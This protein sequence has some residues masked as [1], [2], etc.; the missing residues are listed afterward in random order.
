MLLFL[1][2]LFLSVYMYMYVYQYKYIH[3]FWT[4]APLSLSTRCLFSK[5]KKK[6]LTTVQ[7]KF[8]YMLI[9]FKKIF[10]FFVWQR[11]STSRRSGRQREREKLAP[12]W[13]ESSMWGLIPGLTEPPRCPL[14]H[15]YLICILI[16]CIDLVMSLPH[17]LLYSSIWLWVQNPVEDRIG[18]LVGYI[19]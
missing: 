14:I 16:L 6:Y 9:H 5:N 4:M 8:Q 17:W 15:F 7:L 2:T 11:E 18:H 1:H 10:Y 12:C 19:S 3:F 13:A